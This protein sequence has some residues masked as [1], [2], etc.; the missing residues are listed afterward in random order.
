VE[1]PA[2]EMWLDVLSMKKALRHKVKLSSIV[3]AKSREER[4]EALS[5][6]AECIRKHFELGVAITL[7][8]NAYKNWRQRDK[9]KF[10]GGAD[11]PHYF[12]FLNA[13]L[14]CTQHM[15]AD[16]HLSL[17]CD[18]DSGTAIN[19]YKLYQRVRTLD[20]QIRRSLISITFADDDKFPS[21]QAADFLASLCRLEGGRMFHRVYYEYMSLFM[22][23]TRFDNSSGI[24]WVTRFFDSAELNKLSQKYSVGQRPRISL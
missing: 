10:A 23:L 8:V 9:Q 7:D 2:K 12:I 17:V 18:D 14:G 4:S 24:R 6:F 1:Q 5:P 19:C 20:P 3:A 13:L 15:K 16:D 11:D 21:L 22:K